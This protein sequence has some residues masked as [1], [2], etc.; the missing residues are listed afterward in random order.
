MSANVVRRGKA[1]GETEVHIW[2]ISLVE[3]GRLGKI[4]RWEVGDSLKTGLGDGR[5]MEISWWEMGDPDPC[6]PVV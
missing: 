4:E 1:V 3:D 2:A 6:L 5:S